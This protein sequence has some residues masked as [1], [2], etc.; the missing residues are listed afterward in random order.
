MDDSL[1]KEI[2]F[3]GRG[4]QGAVT[5]ATLLAIA[6]VKEGYHAQGFPFFG[7]ERRGAPVMAFAR[8]SDKPIL[9]HGMFYET[10]SLVVLDSMLIETGQVKKIKVRENGEI[11]INSNNEEHAKPENFSILGDVGIY[12]V[13]ATQIAINHGLVIAGWPV[14]NT[15]ILG[16]FSRATGLVSI[17]SIVSS[18]KEYFG[19]KV[20]EANASSALEAYE[21]VRRVN[22]SG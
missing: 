19:G 14:V 16:A 6:A 13:D 20:G 4:G 12:I 3:Y 8:I 18:I 9:R 22:I 15:G 17:D 7:A 21:K 11:I 2:I 5:S 10:D 1:L